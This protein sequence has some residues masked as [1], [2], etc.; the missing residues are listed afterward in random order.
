MKHLI[1]LL[2]LLT[3]SAVFSQYYPAKIL[4]TTGDIKEG[5]A[6][7]PSNKMLDNKIEFKTT[8]NGTRIDLDE[9]GI[10]QILYT[11]DTGTQFL[12]ERSQA[13]HLFKSFGKEVE[14][15]KANKHWMLLIH[16]NPALNEYSLAQRYKIDKK[17]R[18]VSIV[19]N[20]SFWT[21]IYFLFRKPDAEN[22]YI[23]SG[24]GFTH[25]Q[26]RKAMAIFFK[27][28]PAFVARIEKKEFKNW[29]V[30]KVADAY[31]NSL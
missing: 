26:V 7:L 15:E 16:Q 18:M 22:A 20:G 9:D 14:V 24:K 1:L 27:D 11:A 17:G 10:Y 19:G 31:Y 30:H 5:F 23:V 21:T 6:K 4:M 2:V 8:K 25:G 28:T 12:F 29:D 3:S 13:V